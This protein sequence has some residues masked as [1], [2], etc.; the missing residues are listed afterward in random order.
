MSPDEKNATRRRATVAAPTAKRSA[1]DSSVVGGRS[2][3]VLSR[4]A[5]TGARHVP[6]AWTRDRRFDPRFPVE[7]THFPNMPEWPGDWIPEDYV[8]TAAELKHWD[9]MHPVPIPADWNTLPPQ[10]KR[11]KTINAQAG[12]WCDWEKRAKERLFVPFPS[13]YR[14][15][16]LA[17]L[18]DVNR[19][20]FE[21]TI[22]LVQREWQST[23]PDTEFIETQV[24]FIFADPKRFLLVAQYIH[25]D[26]G[27]LLVGRTV[28]PVTPKPRLV[29]YAQNAQEKIKARYLLDER[30]PQRVLDEHFAKDQ[31]VMYLELVALIMSAPLLPRDPRPVGSPK[32]SPMICVRGQKDGLPWQNTGDLDPVYICPQ[33]FVSTSIVSASLS[34]SMAM[35]FA[36]GVLR[37]IFVFHVAEGVPWLYMNILEHEVLLPPGL[38][39]TLREVHHNPVRSSD[40]YFHIA[41]EVQPLEFN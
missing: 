37:N 16:A 23:V 25:A 26:G 12:D 28:R 36:S 31:L 30:M 32:S 33:T 34:E 15:D 13:T 11:K 6:L 18:D 1:E 21:H 2:R 24:L 29:K 4:T 38:R 9:T 7:D 35:S 20:G 17:S 3:S 41:V 5:S 22:P 8:P 39:W 14:R 19:R 40:V 27:L 10:E